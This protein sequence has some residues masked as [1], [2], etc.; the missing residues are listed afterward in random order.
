MYNSQN[1]VRLEHNLYEHNLLCTLSSL[2]GALRP[3]PHARHWVLPE[4]RMG[5]PSRG[6]RKGQ[7]P[8][9]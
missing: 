7:E 8:I 4:T 1:V 2:P 6:G 3:G 5:V 9:D